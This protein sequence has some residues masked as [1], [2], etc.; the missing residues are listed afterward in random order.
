MAT[1][2]IILCNLPE[3]I[4]RLQYHKLNDMVDALD[5]A[6]LGL[7]V[8]D[9]TPRTIESYEKV[10]LTYSKYTEYLLC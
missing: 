10:V 1:Q 3:V 7:H 9:L 4:K 6:S 5:H 8:W 2:T